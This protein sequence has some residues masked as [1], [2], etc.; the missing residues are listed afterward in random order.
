[1]TESTSMLCSRMEVLKQRIAVTANRLPLGEGM[2]FRSLMQDQMEV[3]RSTIEIFW[4]GNAASPAC[5]EDADDER[6]MDRWREQWKEG[7]K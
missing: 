7:I 4:N 1:M 5:N 3:M 2:L 6:A